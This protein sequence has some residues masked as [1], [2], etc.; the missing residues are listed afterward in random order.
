[1]GHILKEIILDLLLDS[2]NEGATIAHLARM[3]ETADTVAHAELVELE[4]GQLVTR[5]ERL[6]GSAWLL[7]SAGL[8]AASRNRSARRHPQEKREER[9]PVR[10]TMCHHTDAP[11]SSHAT[12]CI[13]EADLDDWWDELD[14]ELKS[15]A[16]LNYSFGAARSEVD[17]TERV[18]VTGTIG[19][20]VDLPN[21][22]LCFYCRIAAP[23]RLFLREARISPS[24][25][26]LRR[27]CADGECFERW[28]EDCTAMANT[29]AKGGELGGE[30]LQPAPIDGD[31]PRDADLVC[32]KCFKSGGQWDRR[33]STPHRQEGDPLAPGEA[34]SYD[35]R[36]AGPFIWTHCCEAPT[37]TIGT[38]PSIQD[39]EKA[40]D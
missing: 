30:P 24:V 39:A 21:T 16:F 9:G 17:V 7:T 6:H 5:V 35:N 1:M 34:M 25:T 33:M 36:G 2:P 23:G 29:V 18:P 31:A 28:I 11:V 14:V 22:T 19:A 20:H 32:T 10:V 27:V 15:A 13:D 40:A 4:I 12:V 38:R 26:I 3:L 8:T 37:E